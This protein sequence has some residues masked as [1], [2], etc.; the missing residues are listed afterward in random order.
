M[1]SPVPSIMI[2]QH[3]LTMEHEKTDEDSLTVPVPS[4]LVAAL[5][6]N[7]GA[8]IRGINLISGRPVLYGRALLK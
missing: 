6:G 7:Q 8:N 5:V 2:G 1:L 3:N 4:H